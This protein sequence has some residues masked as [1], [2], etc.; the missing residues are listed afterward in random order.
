MGGGARTNEWMDGW[1]NEWMNEW[2]NGGIS[3]WMDER[4]TTCIS[5][6]IGLQRQD[7]TLTSFWSQVG[8]VGG[9]RWRSN[10][11]WR[12]IESESLAQPVA[13]L[14]R[15]GAPVTPAT[16]ATSLPCQCLKV[17]KLGTELV[18]NFRRASRSPTPRRSSA[19]VFRVHNPPPSFP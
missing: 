14:W 16:P 1:M 11:H 13:Q 8:G 15:A 6:A 10:R 9:S 2:M 3:G 4:I 18:H 5:K 12:R 17:T 19:S 7:R